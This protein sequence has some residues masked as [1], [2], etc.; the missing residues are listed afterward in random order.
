MKSVSVSELKE[1][2]S[3]YLQRVQRGGEVQ[4][5]NRGRPVARLVGMRGA[6]HN[7]NERR[8]RLISAGVLR[9][10]DGDVSETLPK[11]PLR[12]PGLALSASL[13]EERGDRV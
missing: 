2:L 7:D 1:N 10:G 11:S 4:V 9:V 12:I 3:H 13:T 8:E 5:L 6:A